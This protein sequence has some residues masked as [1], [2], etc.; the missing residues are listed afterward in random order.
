ME[1]AEA[2]VETT[3]PVHAEAS[4]CEL[5]VKDI[6]SLAR[7]ADKIHPD[8]PES[9][10]V[11]AERVELFPEGCLGLWWEKGKGNELCGYVISHPIR[12][13]QPPALNSLLGNIASDADQYY[14]HDLAILPKLRA[15]GLAQECINNKLFAIAKRYPTT[16]LISVYGTEPFWSRFGIV[17][18]QID[19]VLGGK[20]LDYGDD[21][22]YLERKNEEYQRQAT[23]DVGMV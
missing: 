18:V 21:A 23:A 5:S 7:V 11:F 14:I 15:R 10:S 13:L 16:C 3:Q 8:L 19:D 20:L 6:K 17:L 4:W 2:K 1:E 12:R 22:I 9:D